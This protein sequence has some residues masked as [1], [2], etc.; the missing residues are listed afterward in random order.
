MI[1]C[2]KHWLCYLFHNLSLNV[3]NLILA[4]IKKC[5]QFWPKNWVW[6]PPC[7]AGSP[8]P[9][10]SRADR[11]ATPSLPASLCLTCHHA[12]QS[13][14]AWWPR[15]A[16]TAAPVPWAVIGC[17]ARPSPKA[18]GPKAWPNTVHHFS[19]FQNFKNSKNSFK[20]PKFIENRIKLRKIQSKFI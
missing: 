1:R 10:R 11:P 8:S 13:A 7:Q 5:I 19:V 3:W 14:R 4:H 20:V 2:N 12:A 6:H 17:W 15:S 18:L 16:R 9:P